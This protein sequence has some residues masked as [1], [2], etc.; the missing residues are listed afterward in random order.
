MQWEEGEKVP[1]APSSSPT[2]PLDP[3][4]RSGDGSKKI[5]TR[6]RSQEEIPKILEPI[7]ER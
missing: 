7:R 5:R 6:A 4:L 2:L 3:A 1:A